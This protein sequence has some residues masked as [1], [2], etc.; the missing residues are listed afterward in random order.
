MMADVEILYNLSLSLGDLICLVL[1]RGHSTH[2]FAAIQW[3]CSQEMSE[4]MSNV[5]E[6]VRL[7]R[8]ANETAYNYQVNIA[9]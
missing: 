6:K 1:Y 4:K 8:K 9:L 7:S 2:S 5:V 3:L